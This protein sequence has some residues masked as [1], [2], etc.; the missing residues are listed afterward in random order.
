MANISRDTIPLLPNFSVCLVIITDKRMF[1]CFC[2]WSS[3]FSSVQALT[4]SELCQSLFEAKAMNKEQHQWTIKVCF[5]IHIV[6]PSLFERLRSLPL[7]P[8]MGL[9]HCTHSPSL[10][11]TSLTM[12][13]GSSY[14]GD[15]CSVACGNYIISVWHDHVNSSQPLAGYMA[16]LFTVRLDYV[17]TAAT[18]RS[19]VL[20]RLLGNTHL[21]LIMN[22]TSINVT[23]ADGLLLTYRN[24]Y[25]I[26]NCRVEMS[27]NNYNRMSLNSTEPNRE[28][29]THDVACV[30]HL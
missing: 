27:A 13:A 4:C 2:T 24:K 3:H 25:A 20:V 16:Y 29:R 21:D 15:D 26:N 23:A 5:H 1:H 17:W 30:W 6:Q 28:L 18:A 22:Y 19:N 8:S 10:L 11:P 7:D 9:S 14:N 12:S